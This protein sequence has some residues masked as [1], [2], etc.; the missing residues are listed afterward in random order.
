MRFVYLLLYVL[1]FLSLLIIGIS[2]LPAVSY[3]AAKLRHYCVD[4]HLLL[5]MPVQ[6]KSAAAICVLL[7]LTV[8]PL[9]RSLHFLTMLFI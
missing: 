2:L 9:H 5:M 7:Q 3:I 8:S 1:F 4:R 6:I